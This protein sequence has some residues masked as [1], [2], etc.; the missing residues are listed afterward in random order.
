MCYFNYD[1]IKDY[2]Q[3]CFPRHVARSNP[4][5]SRAL[6]DWNFSGTSWDFFQKRS[7]STIRKFTK[8]DHKRNP[9]KFTDFFL[10]AWPPPDGCLR[11]IISKNF[12]SKKT[13]P[14]G[15]YMFKVNS[16]DT[17]TRSEICSE[18]TIKTP[19]RRNSRQL[20]L[21]MFHTLF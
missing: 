18:F 11:R 13:I 8:K 15:N 3:S 2:I 1:I 4:E 19:E 12:H 16:K 6:L 9:E 5:A 20:T 7:T 21:N 10:C 17:R 14:A